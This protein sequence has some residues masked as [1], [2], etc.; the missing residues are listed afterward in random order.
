MYYFCDSRN[1]IEI[2]IIEL[3]FQFNFRCDS[4]YLLKNSDILFGF[5][6]RYNIE[7]WIMQLF[8]LNFVSDSEYLL[9]NADVFFGSEYKG[10]I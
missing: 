2:W 10:D 4:E 3:F 8:Q 7:I 9:K 5:I 6:S 1:N